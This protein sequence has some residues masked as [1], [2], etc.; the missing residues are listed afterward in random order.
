M[1]QV[2]VKL[3][4]VARADWGGLDIGLLELFWNPRSVQAFAWQEYVLSEPE[5]P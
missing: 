4:W 1:A 2:A 3:T 5:R